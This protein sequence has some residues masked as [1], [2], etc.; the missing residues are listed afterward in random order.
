M[1]EFSKSPQISVTTQREIVL[2][3]Y[4]KISLVFLRTPQKLID[5]SEVIFPKTTAN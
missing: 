2:E 3:C 4:L 1:G 5:Y